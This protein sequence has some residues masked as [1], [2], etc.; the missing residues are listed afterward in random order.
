MKPMTDTAEIPPAEMLAP[1]E[2]FRTAA[3]EAPNQA[4]VE[5]EGDLQTAP[6]PANLSEQSKMNQR[7]WIQ[8]AILGLAALG[9]GAVAVF[10]RRRRP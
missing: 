2:H 9:F 1:T 8:Q 4:G 10:L 3:T 7:F 5:A 6:P